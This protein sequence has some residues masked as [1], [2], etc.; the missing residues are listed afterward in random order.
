M[1]TL[2]S[3]SPSEVV[4]I[5][6]KQRIAELKAQY[7]PPHSG[8]SP[9]MPLSCGAPQKSSCKLAEQIEAFLSLATKIKATKKQCNIMGTE[10]ILCPHRKATE[11][12]K[13]VA[14]L[15]L[16]VASLNY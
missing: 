15:S 7:C 9:N 3:A 1:I 4:S 13:F 10:T 12:H 5:L 14:V 11:G 2:M 16:R 6:T 8:A